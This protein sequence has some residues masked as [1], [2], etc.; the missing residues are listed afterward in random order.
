MPMISIWPKPLPWPLNFEG[1]DTGFELAISTGGFSNNRLNVV[2]A[3]EAYCA[4]NRVLYLYCQCI[5]ENRAKRFRCP[6]GLWLADVYDA[7]ISGRSYKEGLSHDEAVE[8]I[9][10]G[11]GMQIHYSSTL[12]RRCTPGL[13]KL[14]LTMVKKVKNQRDSEANHRRAPI[15]QLNAPLFARSRPPPRRWA[16]GIGW[17][18]EIVEVQ[19]GIEHWISWQRDRGRHRAGSPCNRTIR[20]G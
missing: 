1:G 10:A 12:L 4:C 2:V 9:L 3:N 13:K 15:C 6:A 7:L 19:R 18:S 17:E 16:P 8:I 14:T 11:R 5:E 20:P